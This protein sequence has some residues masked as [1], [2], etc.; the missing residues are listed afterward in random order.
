[1]SF[2][3]FR[4]LPHNG[5]RHAVKE[6]AVA[7]E[8]TTTLCGEEVTIPAGRLGKEEWSWPTCRDCDAAW[9]AAEG[10]LPIPHQLGAAD[11]SARTPGVPA[12]PR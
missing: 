8:E 7:C 4:W 6:D 9:R 12:T 5:K 10:I 3:P 2:R 11:V 1:M